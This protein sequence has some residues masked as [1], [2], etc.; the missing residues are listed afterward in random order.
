[1]KKYAIYKYE[2]TRRSTIQKDLLQDTE[3]TSPNMEH[4]YENFEHVFGGKGVELMAL[5]I[6]VSYMTSGYHSLFHSQKIAY[7]KIKA[8]YVDVFSDDNLDE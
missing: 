4:A 6:A 1:M 5:A 2:L 7:S 8:K 3:E